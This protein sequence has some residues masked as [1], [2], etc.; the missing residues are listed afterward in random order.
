M[1]F[2]KLVGLDIGSSSIRAVEVSY[3]DDVI[4]EIITVASIKMPTHVTKNG[5]IE[6]YDSFLAS[7]KQ[8]WL[9]NK[10]KTKNVVLGVNGQSVL[11][12]LV[13]GLPSEKTEEIFQKTLPYKM[14][15]IIPT[16]IN[17]YYLSSHTIDEYVDKRGKKAQVLRDCL[18]VGVEKKN[19][20]PII[21]A[22]QTAGLR[23]YG[24]DIVPLAIIRSILRT[25]EDLEK[26]YASIDIG[27]DIVTIIVH[28]N[29]VPEYIRT[30]NGIGGNTINSRISEELG[31][32]II[33][34][35]IEK[36]KAL[37]AANQ[38]AE[39][40]TNVFGGGQAGLDPNS[41]EAALAQEINLIVAQEITITIKQ[42]RDTLTDA[43]TFS[44][45]IDS[46]IDEVVLSGAGAGIN[47]IASRMQNE[48]GIPVRYNTPFDGIKIAAGQTAQNI[49]N[50]TIHPYEYAAAFGLLFGGKI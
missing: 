41:A 25:P 7:I 31:L 9:D 14:A 21:L 28:K 39:T 13:P 32:N 35:E 36:F 46:P 3:K 6:S 42:I 48:L 34:S 27:G 10:I 19:L 26:R 2:K 17:N 16:G 38:V 8:L 33:Q 15:D 43:I 50:G 23:V 12:R 20:D 45:I 4:D 5:S 18:V 24:V 1:T 40:S 30:I 47:T 11:T 44:D 29:G 22:L 37:S 49:E